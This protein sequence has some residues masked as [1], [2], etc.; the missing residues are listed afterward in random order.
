MKPLFFYTMSKNQEEVL[1]FA[2]Q[3]TIED[4]VLVSPTLYSIN[5]R[6]KYLLW[7]IFIAIIDKNKNQID[8]TEEYIDRKE[9]PKGACGAYWSVSGTEDMTMTKSNVTYISKGKN[10]G[11]KNYTTAFTQAIIDAKS[12]FNK[13]I[14]SGHKYDKE[15]IIK[16]GDEV[17]FERLLNDTT[18]GSAPWRVYAM[19]LHDYKKFS[20]K[21]HFPAFIQ[22]KLD[23]TLFIVVH[24]PSLP[25][26]KVDD[27]LLKIDGYSRSRESYEQQNHILKELY[28]V[29]LAYPGLHFVGEL[30]K[31]G[32]GLQEISGFSRRKADTKLEN[33]IKMDFN[34]FDCFELDQNYSFEERQFILEEAMLKLENPKYVHVIPSEPVNNEKELF[35]KY[36]KYLELKYEGAV[37]RNK[38]APYEF[39][40]EKEIRSYDTQ[41]LKPRFDGEWP[42]VNFGEGKGKETG[43]IKWICADRNSDKDLKDRETFAVTPNQPTELRKKIFKKLK[44]DPEFFKKEIFGQEA[45][46]SYS[47]L[48]NTGFPQQPKMLRFRNI[49]IDEMLKN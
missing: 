6:N 33:E 23:G 28:P 39:G 5:T 30:W 22:Y 2:E 9:L 45:V 36:E 46:I 32:Y 37:I 10:T 4:G 24:H 20:N 16:K 27:Q 40:V 1:K 47:I 48:S 21:I 34:I 17:S 31:E 11:K 43:A 14:K 41:K 8:V 38:N 26:I 15:D 7:T 12:I 13:K 49:K 44:E 19:A 29:A 3:S 35:E 18:R 42:I 25:E